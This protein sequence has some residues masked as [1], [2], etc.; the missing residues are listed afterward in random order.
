MAAQYA[1]T[2][3]MAKHADSLTGNTTYSDMLT[4][5][6][7]EEGADNKTLIIANMAKVLAEIEANEDDAFNEGMGEYFNGD[8]TGNAQIRTD[9]QAFLAYMDGVTS[10]SG[11]ILEDN[12]LNNS[13]FFADRNT[14]SINQITNSKNR[15]WYLN[16]FEQRIFKWQNNKKE[17]DKV[18]KRIIVEPF[19]WNIEQNDEGAYYIKIIFSDMSI[20]HTREGIG[21]GYWSI[22]TIVD[23][24]YDSKKNDLIVID[25]PELSLHP[26]F[27]NFFCPSY[28][29][30]LPTV[31]GILEC[32]VR[33][34][35]VCVMPLAFFILVKP[36]ALSTVTMQGKFTCS[37]F[38]PNCILKW[39][40]N[41]ANTFGFIHFVCPGIC[42]L[43][44]T[45]S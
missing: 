9:A 15:A 17:F 14:Y 11:A 24:L 39:G 23:A 19:D 28:Q 26:T 18:L 41:S 29:C 8:G 27:Q 31:K 38:F 45:P 6:V 32:P 20:S 4:A 16:Q 2:L 3:A 7:N 25:E 42:K 5:G 40:T 44:C 35:T 30:I 12:N 13:N 21:D 1:Y 36:T 33:S 34:F 22:F 43:P 10:N 37:E